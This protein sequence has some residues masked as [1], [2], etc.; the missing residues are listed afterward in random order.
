MPLGAARCQRNDGFAAFRELGAP[1][2]VQLPARSGIDGRA[3]GVGTHLA[4]EVYL[5]GGIDGDHMGVEGYHAGV[6]GVGDVPHLHRRVPMDEVVHFL[7]AQ[8]EG[9]HRLSPVD[10]FAGVVDNAFLDK[11]QRPVGE[12]LRMQAQVPVVLEGS[13]DGVG[14]GAYPHLQAGPVGDELGAVSAYF[15]VG[16][17]GLYI[18]LGI[19]GPMVPHQ[20]GEARKGNQVS[21]GEGNA[22]I[23]HGDAFPRHFQGGQGT[24]YRGAQGHHAVHGLR[25]LHQ[26]YVAAQ[27]T[28]AVHQLRLKEVD[29]N[30]V[31]HAFP[32]AGAQVGPH[33]EA[34]VE[35]GL[36]ELPGAIGRRS[37]RMEM[38]E[39]YIVELSRPLAQGLDEDV[40]HAGDAGKM[41][42]VS[43]PYGFDGLPGADES[44][45]AHSYKQ[46]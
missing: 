4:A 30:V 3:D 40:R 42:M 7:R 9:G 8:Q 21:V 46:R 13:A 38:V 5:D 20:G 6:V 19:Q 22:R 37:F 15:Q 24:V 25:H 29:G 34:L 12:H 32:D 36:A 43:A 17:G 16:G 14:Q 41:H 31:C 26:G 11:L 35:E 45:L 10:G 27:G 23:D 1:H 18:F 28:G 39:M 33:E 44:F 2:E